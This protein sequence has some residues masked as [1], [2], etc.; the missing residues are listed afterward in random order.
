MSCSQNSAWHVKKA[1][2]ALALIIIVMTIVRDSVW[3][4]NSRTTLQRI[5]VVLK[6]HSEVVA[7]L[8]FST[9]GTLKV[10]RC[11]YVKMTPFTKPW[12]VYS[13][14]SHMLSVISQWLVSRLQVSCFL[15]NRITVTGQ[16]C[17]V[18]S[19]FRQTYGLGRYRT[20]P[21]FAKL[22]QSPSVSEGIY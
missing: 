1:H 20:D 15:P 10:L 17:F 18:V 9:S 16:F 7:C 8:I 21:G 13:M 22:D 11:G 4:V 2:L 6:P 12:T 14:K 5:T 19:L 3:S